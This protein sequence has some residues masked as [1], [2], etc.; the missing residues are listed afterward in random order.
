MVLPHQPQNALFIDGHLLD[1]AQIRPNPA[2]APERR[3]SLQLL[4]VREQTLILL[5][6]PQ[7][8]VQC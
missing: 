4:N 8:S 3:R 6:H 2:A 1:Q 5:G 7:R